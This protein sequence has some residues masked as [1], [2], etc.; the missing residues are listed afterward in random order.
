MHVIVAE[1]VKKFSFA[2]VQKWEDLSVTGPTYP[3][4][5]NVEIVAAAQV[6]LGDDLA[7]YYMDALALG[8]G[9]AESGRPDFTVGFNHSQLAE[10][11]VDVAKAPIPPERQRRLQVLI[12]SHNDSPSPELATLP[13]TE[14]DY[15]T[16]EAEAEFNKWK[17]TYVAFES[18][19]Q[20]FVAK[21]SLWVQDHS[22]RRADKELK[23]H[24]EVL[25]AGTFIK[26]DLVFGRPQAA[27][28]NFL[29]YGVP[30][31]NLISEEELYNTDIPLADRAA[32][33][34]GRLSLS[35]RGVVAL[36]QVISQTTRLKTYLSSKT[37]NNKET[38]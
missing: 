19:P 22:G 32:L 12:Q 38:K 11:F 15:Q 33:P 21:E 36:A 34:H 4:N 18:G 2:N 30:M 25:I 20:L 27:V 3:F 9:F 1:G 24:H 10:G 29:W 28:K 23:S 17:S 37:K 35:E 5:S 26:D 7:T 13:T 6:P 8:T 31:V 16:V 14:I